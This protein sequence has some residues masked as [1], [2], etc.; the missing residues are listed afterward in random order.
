MP[1]T[2]LV[3][4][5]LAPL[6]SLVP[7]AAQGNF[8]L[9]R[10]TTGALGDVLQFQHTGVPQPFLVLGASFTT[11]TTPLPPELSNRPLDIA[12]PSFLFT[13]VVAA[14][15]GLTTP[16]PVPNN[17]LLAGLTIQW[18]AGALPGTTQLFD[19]LSNRTTTQLA[20]PLVPTQLPATTVGRAWAARIRRPDPQGGPGTW[21]FAGGALRPTI[22]Q[23]PLQTSEVFDPLTLEVTAG[24]L[25]PDDVYAMTTTELLDGTTLLTGGVTT[26]PANPAQQ[27]ATDGAVLYEPVA[28]TFT[29]M[30][31]MSTPRFL[32]AAARLP[33]GRVVVVGG[34]ATADLS[35]PVLLTNSEVFDP[36]TRTWSPG[37]SLAAPW[38]W[39][40]LSSLPNGE[41]LLHGG[42]VL[43][44]FG[45]VPAPIC[46][47]LLTGT[48]GSLSWAP[49]APMAQPR[50]AHDRGTILL[51]DGRLLI[52]GGCVGA[53]FGG[54]PVLM[55]T[56]AV[57]TYDST[58]G[59]WTAG[60]FAPRP[61]FSGT[62]DQL[63]NGVV[64]ATGGMAGL[65]A[66]APVNTYP[67]N[68]VLQWDPQTGLWQQLFSM[69]QPRMLGGSATTA[70]GLLV[71]LGG[72][73]VTSGGP[74]NTTVETLR[75]W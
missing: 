30:P 35:A 41:L 44:P 27:D 54:V 31:P 3:P 29:A 73:V 75:T 7:L 49:G 70:E 18:Q 26:L 37:P 67:L 11:G 62:L 34:S 65:L 24:P 52:A 15:N 64:I 57:E 47:R 56:D 43:T 60:A 51:A 50:V 63:P 16:I 68:D 13:E 20:Q 45:L 9:Q 17:L 32:H 5:C 69:Q 6:L 36:A 19:A 58:A 21:L 72:Q 42:L 59:T 40:A 74:S 38:F 2:P 23:Q 53:M 12:P 28:N 46:Q 1:T 55:G 8:L 39:G 25:L 22:Q 10:A 33:D 4:L 14:P 71:L 61:L 48:G 66:M